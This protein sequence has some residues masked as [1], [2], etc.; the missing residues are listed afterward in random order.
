MDIE[1]WAANRLAGEMADILAGGY[2]DVFDVADLRLA[3]CH[4][5]DEAF[6]APLEGAIKANQ[7][8]PAVAENDGVPARYAAFDFDGTRVLG[9]SAGYRDDEPAPQLKFR[10]RMIVKDADVLVDSFIF[11]V[12]AAEAASPS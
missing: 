8:K 10:T 7:F 6:A 4:F 11:S 3:R 2:V 12:V 9:G 1:A 5:A